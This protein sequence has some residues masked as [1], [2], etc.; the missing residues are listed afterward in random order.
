MKKLIL[1]NGII[2]GII[3]SIMMMISTI[4]FKC[5][6]NME[7]SMVIGYTG[8]LIAFSFVFIGIRNY[9]NKQNGGFV[10]FGSA[11]K[12]GLLI[13]LIASTFYVVSW[14]I[15]YYCFFPNFMEK[16]SAAAIQK[17]ENDPHITAAELTAQ[18]DQIKTM[19]EMYKNPIWVILFTY[20]EIF[21]LGIIISLI[22]ALILKKKPQ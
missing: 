1:T 20:A 15:E 7:S 22:S 3:V 17:I 9:R 5:D 19:Q 2:G 16:Y 4:V 6:P 11:F 18:V 8:M 21:P 10:N 14:L 12:I 13:S